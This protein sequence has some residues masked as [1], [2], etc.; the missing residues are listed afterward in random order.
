MSET[1]PAEQVAECHQHPSKAAIA[2]C[3]IC[4]RP[5]CAECSVRSGSKFFC[6]ETDH[7][8]IAES[9]ILIHRTSFEFEVDMI[10]KNLGIRGIT[11]KAFSPRTFKYHLGEHPDDAASVYVRKSDGGHAQEVLT[12]LGLASGNESQDNS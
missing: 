5:L 9:W 11:A 2:S 6:S 3:A 10:S 7:Q 12:V 8:E 1:V 4:G